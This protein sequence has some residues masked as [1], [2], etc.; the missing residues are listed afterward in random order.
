MLRGRVDD[1]K[2]IYRKEVLPSLAAMVT[3]GRR[4]MIHMND[5]TR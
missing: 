4:V 2:S 1:N 5:D 3:V